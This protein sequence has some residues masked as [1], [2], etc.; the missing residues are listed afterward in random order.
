LL[1]ASRSF[2]NADFLNLPAS[3]LRVSFQTTP[4]ATLAAAF[5]LAARLFVAPSASSPPNKKTAETEPG[6]FLF[7][8][9]F[10]RRPVRLAFL[11]FQRE[12]YLPPKYVA[13][14]QNWSYLFSGPDRD[15]IR[16]HDEGP[17]LFDRIASGQF[18]HPLIVAVK[19]MNTHQKGLEQQKE[20]QDQQ[21]DFA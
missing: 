4:R 2:K 18:C 19:A 9:G 6:G 10:L 3:S 20:R 1:R 7:L 14:A 11:N 8:W 13:L 16:L 15:W 5:L 17:Y 21:K 12:G